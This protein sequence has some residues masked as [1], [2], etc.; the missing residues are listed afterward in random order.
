MVDGSG[1]PARTADVAVAD[2][3]IVEV[4]GR[5]GPARREVEADRLAIASQDLRLAFGVD[6]GRG[7]TRDMLR[8]PLWGQALARLNDALGLCYEVLKLAL[9][10]GELET[11]LSSVFFMGQILTLERPVYAGTRAEKITL[12]MCATELAVFA[13]L[14]FGARWLAPWFARPRAWQVLD[15]LIGMTMWLLAALLVRHVWSGW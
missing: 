5:L 7:N 12:V 8:Q 2:G 6:G 15:A 3:R 1:G 14:G 9:G 13:A 10:R 4:G 11:L